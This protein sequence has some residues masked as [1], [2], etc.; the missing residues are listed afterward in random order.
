MVRGIAG[1]GFVTSWTE[2]NLTLFQNHWQIMAR[3]YSGSFTSTAKPVSIDPT[4]D[5]SSP[6]IAGNRDGLMVVWTSQGQDGSREGVFGRFLT[7]TGDPIGPE[8]QVNTYAES[9]QFHPA[10][11]ADS[12]N[13]FLVVW[14]SFVG[15]STTFDLLAQRYGATVGVPSVT[16]G[17]VSPS[18]WRITWTAEPGTTY[19]VQSA[20]SISAPFTD[21]GTPRVAA[22]T[23]DFILLDRNAGSGF[24]RV[25]VIP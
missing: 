8:F 19:Q 7:S 2:R 5:R 21:V 18:Q 17:R 24:Y 22:G 1:G 25:K 14:S 6:R 11:S 15:G 10:L 20:P 12:G 16:F 9:M 3:T 23:N 4:G 13:Q